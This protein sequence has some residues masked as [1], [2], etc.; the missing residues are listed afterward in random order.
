LKTRTLR[1]ALV[2]FGNVGRCFARGLLGPY[3][4][5][6]GAAGLRV[7]VTGIATGRHGLVVE[8]RGLDLA[9]VLRIVEA[10]RSLAELQRGEGPRSATELVA[11]AP[12]D[13][14]V[15]LTPLDP[16][17]GEPATTHIRTALGRGLHAITANKGPVA[18]AR[19]SLERL[20][21]RKRRLFLHEGAVM[22][23]TPVFSFVE[24]CLP[25]ARVLAFRGTL[26]GTTGVVLTRMEEGLS[27]EEAV[28]EAQALG[29]AEA[30]PAHDLEGWDAAFKGA[31]LAAALW[32][33][34]VD[35]RRIPRQ[36]IEGIT[37]EEV[38]A[39]ARSGAGLRLVVRGERRG[40]RVRVTVAPERVPS[41]DPLAGRA[42]DAAL[43]L[44]T[45][46]CGEI[47]VVE[48]VGTVEQTAYAVLSDLLTIASAA[49][50]ASAATAGSSRPRSR[51][52][53][54]RA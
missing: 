45:D 6:L 43:L 2:G 19:R 14:L 16:R 51:A 26:N 18:F 34:A 35:P 7:A 54:S 46:L 4:R 38:R 32:D 53:G 28:A 37:A 42:G 39:A 27:R 11:R 52:R 23:G 47:G 3:R 5:A 15:E 30:D 25:G 44:R 50:T 20:A 21:A 8:P 1:M 33:V 24:R 49:G 41:G 22:D 36:G 40:R 9:R 12:A 31:A 10:G 29:I 13:V 48:R 17:R